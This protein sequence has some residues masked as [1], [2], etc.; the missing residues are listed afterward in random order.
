[1]MMRVSIDGHL[2]K[3]FISTYPNLRKL[4]SSISVNTRLFNSLFR[5]RHPDNPQIP[6]R[7]QLFTFFQQLKAFIPGNFRRSD[8][9][10]NDEKPRLSPNQGPAMD[11]L[12]DSGSQEQ[13]MACVRSR[14]IPA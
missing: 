5:S 12:G 10:L 9:R 6:L 11:L 2:R 1:M 8:Q 14:P 4:A 7:R 13:E 3:K